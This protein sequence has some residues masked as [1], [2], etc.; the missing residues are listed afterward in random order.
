MPNT[1]DDPLPGVCVARCCSVT[2]AGRSSLLES[3]LAS[4]GKGVCGLPLAALT[5]SRSDAAVRKWEP[6]TGVKML[7]SQTSKKWEPWTR[8]KMLPS[9]TSRKWEPWTGVKMLPSQ[10]SRPHLTS[11]PKS[12]TAHAKFCSIGRQWRTSARVSYPTL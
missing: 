11:G 3:E 10:T 12:R 8:V 1:R 5:T 6:R 7:P 2:A 9:Q 4:G